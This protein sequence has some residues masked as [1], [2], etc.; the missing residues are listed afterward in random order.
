MVSQRTPCLLPALVLLL[1]FDSQS[2]LAAGFQGCFRRALEVPAQRSFS[3][4]WNTA[5]T[6]VA[7][8]DF[9][10][11]AIL[12]YS[13]DGKVVRRVAN[14]GLGSL[15][16]TKPAALQALR[17]GYLLVDAPTH[18]VWFDS[19]W[20]AFR[21]LDPRTASAST[22]RVEVI[23]SPHLVEKSIFTLSP[24][25]RDGEYAGWGLAR[26]PIEEPGKAEILIPFQADST[27]QDLYSFRHDF[28]ATVGEKVFFLHYDPPVKILEAWPHRRTLSVVPKELQKL[29]TL[30]RLAAREQVASL[31]ALISRT[32]M[33]VGLFSDGE[34]IYLLTRKVSADSKREWLLSRID[35][36]ADRVVHTVVLPTNA[37]N[38][39]LVP[40]KQR[41]LLLE[42]EATTLDGNERIAWI[43]GVPANWITSTPSPLN[44][45]V[46]KCDD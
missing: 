1:W 3:A 16:F 37:P 18:L 6:E 5:E 35:E 40:G 23:K 22:T 2:G 7:L 25:S 41:W 14:P 9:A 11:A 39:L 20:N 33:P 27:Q 29:P 26:V 15:E 4:V 46:V 36:A 12:V 13:L 17:E 38:L 28:V 32:T 45:A 31:Q 43:V 24:L 44:A 42:K 19:T 21:S 30:P 34:A 8:T 10:T